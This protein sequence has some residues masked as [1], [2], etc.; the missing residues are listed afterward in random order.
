MGKLSSFKGLATSFRSILHSLEKDPAAWS[1]AQWER[2]PVESGPGV[3]RRNPPDDASSSGT[4]LDPLELSLAA[5]G[6][7]AR[8]PPPD[9]LALEPKGIPVTAPASIEPALVEQAVRRL[10]I[11]GDRRRGV[12][13]IEL[14]GDYAGTTIWVRGEGKAIELEVVLGPGL[15]AEGLPERLLGRLRQSGLDVCSLDVR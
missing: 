14:D 13:R 1:V 11:G 12:A 4:R 7:A 15:E 8:L 5:P 9:G 3:S 2:S 6:P 10:V